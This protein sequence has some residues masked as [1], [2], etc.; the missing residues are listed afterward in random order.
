MQ[1]NQAS[2][3]IPAD[4][5]KKLGVH[6][7]VYEIFIYLVFLHQPSVVMIIGIHILLLVQKA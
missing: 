2:A 5:N 3:V 4:S 6:A 7:G 1:L